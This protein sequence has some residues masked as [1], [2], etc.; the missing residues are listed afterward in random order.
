LA[1]GSAVKR[2]TAHWVPSARLGCAPATARSDACARERAGLKGTCSRDAAGGASPRQHR[3]R[4]MRYRGVCCGCLAPLL[5]ASPFVGRRSRLAATRWASSVR[6]R[7]LTPRCD[8]AS[9]QRSLCLCAWG[10]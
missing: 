7:L 10:S 8:G 5:F 9:R 1:S 6:G 3:A 4:R 2:R